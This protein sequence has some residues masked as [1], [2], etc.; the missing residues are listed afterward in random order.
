MD[1]SSYVNS[2]FTGFWSGE[3]SKSIFGCLL[4]TDSKTLRDIKLVCCNTSIIFNDIND[5]L[6]ILES[7]STTSTHLYP[8][9]QTESKL[10]SFKGFSI[11]NTYT[12]FI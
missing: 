7:G 8:A 10:D 4:S 11:N 3:N 9:F 2:I 6:P 1:I 5:S 12:K